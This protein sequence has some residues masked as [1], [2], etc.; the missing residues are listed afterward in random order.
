MTTSTVPCPDG[1]L[2]RTVRVPD[3]DPPPSS[4]L[5]LFI[6]VSYRLNPGLE[7]QKRTKYKINGAA[8]TAIEKTNPNRPGFHLYPSVVATGTSTV[9]V[10]NEYSTV[11]VLVNGIIWV[12]QI[13]SAVRYLYNAC[14]SSADR[15]LLSRDKKA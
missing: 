15:P 13:D 1:P 4:A 7:E 10:L 14:T 6:L 2:D 12:L 11:P 8:T 9:R 5:S 3:M